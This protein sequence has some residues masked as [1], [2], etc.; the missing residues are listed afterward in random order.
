MVCHPLSGATCRYNVQYPAVAPHSSGNG[1][2]F[3]AFL[4]LNVHNF[5]KRCMHAITFS[6]LVSFYSETFLEVR[7]LQ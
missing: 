5:P 1:H 4:C 2:W 3:V 7:A 6:P